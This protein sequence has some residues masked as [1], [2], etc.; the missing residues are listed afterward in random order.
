MRNKYA[1][2]S[3]PLKARI[4]RVLATEAIRPLWESF[5]IRLQLFKNKKVNREFI[6]QHPQ[7]ATPSPALA[8]DAFD[9]INW[10][11][12]YKFGKDMATFFKDIICKYHKENSLTVLDWGCGPG[13]VI[14]HLPAVLKAQ[15]DE[16]EVHATDYNHQTIDWCR[17][18]IPEVQFETNDMQPPLVHSKDKFDV[19][20]NL[21]VFTHLTEELQYEWIAELRRV[22]K[23]GG[24]LI[25]TL[26]GDY[27]LSLMTKKEK[28]DYLAG[29]LVIRNKDSVGK[30]ACT[31]FHPESFVRQ[32]F[33]RDFDLLEHF[34]E[35]Y[36]LD[37]HQEVWVGRK[38]F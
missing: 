33:L 9:R 28:K 30:K 11:K 10:P 2:I 35:N 18:N 25:V 16:L 1:Y 4:A 14:Q 22:L 27:L 32:H 12:D 37:F 38:P 3:S 8:L 23:P 7:Y 31:A 34:P 36:E 24:L 29:R 15:Y 13:R 6:T 5:R 19:V 26:H 21:S 17:Q 20:Y